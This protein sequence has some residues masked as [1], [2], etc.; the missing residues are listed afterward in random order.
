LK[1]LINTNARSARL[2]YVCDFI[3]SQS[4]HAEWSY[5]EKDSKAS[6]ISIG[7]ETSDSRITL[8]NSGLLDETE[9]KKSRRHDLIQSIKRLS[10]KDLHSWKNEDLF[11]IVFYLLSRYDEYI[12]P[13]RDQHDRFMSRS[14]CLHDVGMIE[15][16]L[17]DQII[18]YLRA[19]LNKA[20]GLKLALTQSE[21]ISTID[22]DHP[23][24]RKNMKW[25]YYLIKKKLQNNS[26]PYDTFHQIIKAH[27]RIRHEP[28]FFFLMHDAAPYEKINRYKNGTYQGLITQIKDQGSI[29]MHPPYRSAVDDSTMLN[30]TNQFKRLTGESPRISRQHYLRLKL[31]TTYRLL[32]KYGIQEDY[33]MGFAE[34][35]G[36]RAGTARTFFWYDLKNET[37][38]SLRLIPLIA[39]DVTLKNYM[40]LTPAEAANKLLQLKTTIDTYGG[41]MSLLWHNSSLSE[42]DDWEDYARV[43]FDFLAT[44]E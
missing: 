37:P 27:D 34:R 10:T 14:S 29:G 12:D 8:P 9:I 4:L 41:N 44:Y 35:V 30:A 11:A 40:N 43:Y 36:F 6:Q 39:M 17:V 16:P 42:I 31:P 25:P 13:S 28:L 26:D 22:V 24:Y 1:I 33:T 5:H 23:W 2:T 20:F 7:H 3:F 21:L 18:C 19:K 38:T 15:F 32:N